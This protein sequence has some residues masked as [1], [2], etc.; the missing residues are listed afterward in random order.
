[1]T[2]PFDAPKNFGS[3]NSPDLQGNKTGKSTDLHEGIDKYQKPEPTDPSKM[4]DETV[5]HPE[6]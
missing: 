3:G 5:V 4:Q 6:D 1:M 2:K